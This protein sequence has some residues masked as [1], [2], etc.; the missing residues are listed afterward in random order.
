MMLSNRPVSLDRTGYLYDLLRGDT[1]PLHDPDGFLTGFSN[2]VFVTI[3]R[4]LATGL[5][6]VI[7]NTVN[8]DVNF[9]TYQPGGP[10]VKYST[11]VITDEDGAFPETARLG[12]PH[13][14]NSYFYDR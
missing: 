10:Y 1:T 14:E 5:L 7:D 3:D 4:E 13:H 8:V 9:K 2:E 11:V 6:S 12:P